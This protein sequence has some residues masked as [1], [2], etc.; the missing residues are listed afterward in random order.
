MN[1]KEYRHTS[2]YTRCDNKCMYSASEVENWIKDNG[3]LTQTAC[4]DILSESI[5]GGTCLLLY[6]W[7]VVL[8]PGTIWEE[9]MPTGI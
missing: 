5:Q 6:M 9:G 8:D 7:Q 4:Q 2:A 3:T 1:S